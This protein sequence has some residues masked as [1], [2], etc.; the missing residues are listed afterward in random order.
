MTFVEFC[1]AI[2]DHREITFTTASGHEMTCVPSGISQGKWGKP[3]G[4]FVFSYEHDGG[5]T[6]G[7]AF[8]K[9]DSFDGH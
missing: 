4:Q 3:N 6:R 8:I 1:A 5:R 9:F 7:T 2:Y